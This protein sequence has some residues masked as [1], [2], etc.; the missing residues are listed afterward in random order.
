MLSE[1]HPHNQ[2]RFGFCEISSYFNVF[3]FFFHDMSR[4]QICLLQNLNLCSLPHYVLILWLLPFCY[5]L[6]LCLPLFL[7]FCLSVFALAWFL[8]VVV[9]YFI[10]RSFSFLIMIY[11]YLCINLN[12]N[13]LLNLIKRFISLVIHY[14]L[15]KNTLKII[16]K[17]RLFV[18]CLDQG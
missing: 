3:A 8:S 11:Y 16:L 4:W 17:E 10:P 7:S 9:F 15:N 18:C 14:F 6:S 1:F 5:F 13:I 2:K 12:Q